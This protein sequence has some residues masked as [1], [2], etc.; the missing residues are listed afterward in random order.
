MTRWGCLALSAIVC[1]TSA[2]RADEAQLAALQKAADE[3][4][5]AQTAGEP[6]VK[7]ARENAKKLS[8]AVTAL[9]IDF[10][11]AEATHADLVAK[12]TAARDAFTKADDERKAALDAFTAA[13]KAALDAQGKENAAA[14]QDAYLKAA[15]ALAAKVTAA[16]TAVDAV[17]PAVAAAVAPQEV[18]AGHPPKIAAAEKAVTEFQPSLQQAE[19]A[20][21]ALSK[22]ALD[23]QIAHEAALIAAGQLVSFAKSVAPIFAQRCVACHNA[24]TAKGRLNMETYANLMKGGES[25]AV[26]MA[27]KSADSNLQMQIDAGEMPKDADPLTPEQI[28]VVKKWIDTGARL[29]AGVPA[30]AQLITIMPKPIQPPPP[31]TYRVPVPVM[32]VAFSPDGNLVA[33]SG[34]R[35]VLLWNAADGQLVRR[36]SNL[37]ERPHDIEFTPNGELLAVAA[38]TPGQLGEVKLFKVADGSLAADLFTT[39]DEVFSVAISPDGNRI[40]ASCADRSVRVYDL[41]T[42]QRLVFIEDHADWVMDVAWSPDGTK[43]ATASR[44]KTAKVFDAK[45]GD[46][47]STFNGH[48]QP[49]FGVGFLPD[50]SQVVSG[51]RDNKLR[52]WAVTDAKQAREIGGFGGEV[53]R[54]VVTPDGH[55]LATSADKQIRLHKLAD[56]SQ[57]RA[58]AGHNEWVYAVAPHLASKRIV[59]GSHDGE[60]RLWNFDDGKTTLNF[61]AAPGYKPQ[62]AAAK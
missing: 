23:H 9:K 52:V 30:T 8:D 39:D 4:R 27:H 26:V 33:T 21:A 58:F 61:I 41:A 7:A 49:V 28:A 59:S 32:A 10:S 5:A 11:K 45:T 37:A 2:A 12:A 42:K 44:D 35:E 16:K 22:T 15:E 51:G 46:A 3:S 38:G 29:D 14:T 19:A 48:G 40:A 20:Y 18:L 36:I 13:R 6:A 57:V 54:L 25:G 47:L 34:Y 53:F 62:V 55:S 50:G 1:V 60:V 31:E 24:R 43:L 17:A 56:G